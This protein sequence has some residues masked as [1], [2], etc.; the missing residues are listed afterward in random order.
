MPILGEPPKRAYRL[1]LGVFVV[2]TVLWWAVWAIFEGKLLGMGWAFHF[3]AAGTTG[4][5]G[6]GAVQL[7]AWA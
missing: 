6:F 3:V 7:V 4:A 2:V 1:S 5:L